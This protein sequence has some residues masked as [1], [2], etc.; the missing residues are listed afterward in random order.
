MRRMS[1]LM[2]A[3]AGALFA[4]TAL[5]ACE[6]V[7]V[8]G[9]SVSAAWS[10]ATVG[11]DRPGVVYLTI[12]NMGADADT[13]TGIATPVA[14]MPMLH[15][16]VVSNGV[17]TMQHAMQVPVP[18]LGT[19]TLQPGGL[20]GMLMGL[21]QAL[22][23]GTSFPVTLTFERAGA[24]EVPVVVRSIGAAESGCPAP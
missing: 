5:R 2:L 24:V 16:T 1:T 15:E 8:D 21:T 3:M 11:A 22:E 14:G 17:A 20:H 10:R 23:E 13:L 9:L 18:S 12:R 7:T 4:G 19:V 6:T